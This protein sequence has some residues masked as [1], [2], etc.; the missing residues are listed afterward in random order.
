[1]AIESYVLWM[2]VASLLF[3][4]LSL[5]FLIKT[6]DYEK[7]SFESSINVFLFGL[8]IM[9]LVKLVDV[10]VYAHKVYP[11]IVESLGIESYLGSMTT[12][13]IVALAPLFAVCIL[14]AVVFARDAFEL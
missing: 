11:D 14:M 2:D 7:T 1:M 8:L 9:L 4:L 5:I 3:V 12:I 10:V 6:R 13:S